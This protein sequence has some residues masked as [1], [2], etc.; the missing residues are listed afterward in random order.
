VLERCA[1][2]MSVPPS[3]VLGGAN[4]GAKSV[5]AAYFSRW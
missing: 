5:Q 2:E 3:V 1:R 4:P